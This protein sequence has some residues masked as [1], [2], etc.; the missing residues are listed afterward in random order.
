VFCV[1]N[2]L[3]CI[4]ACGKCHGVEC[5]NADETSKVLEVTDTEDLTVETC[6]LTDVMDVSSFFTHRSKQ[7]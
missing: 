7:N 6:E 5:A 4:A 1:K 3:K 2:K